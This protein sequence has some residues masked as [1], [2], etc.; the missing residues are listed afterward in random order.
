MEHKIA[1][2]KVRQRIIQLEKEKASLTK[3]ITMLKNARIKDNVVKRTER[4]W[5]GHFTLSN[6]CLFRRNTLLTYKD[7]EIVVSTVGLLQDLTNVGKRPT[8]VF[9]KLAP[10]RFFE[11][12]AFYAKSYDLKYHD[13]DI[14]HQVPFDSKW[15]INKIDADDE[16]NKM[17]EAVVAEISE[18][19][20]RG[21]V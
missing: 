8:Y 15:S 18:K 1:L 19:L 21:D 10:G 20:L 16:A 11:T 2:E 5:G 13:A 6:L 17:H 9:D 7:V 3:T 12:L 14:H 4:G